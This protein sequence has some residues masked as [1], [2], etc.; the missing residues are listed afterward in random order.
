[1]LDIAPMIGIIMDII[2]EDI[3]N[4]GIYDYKYNE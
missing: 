3:V 2:R 1:M 4:P